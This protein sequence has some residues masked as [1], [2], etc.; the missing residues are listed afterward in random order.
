MMRNASYER[1]IRRSS[2]GIGRCDGIIGVK[3]EKVR[4][5][6]EGDGPSQTMIRA[7]TGVGIEARERNWLQPRRM[8]EP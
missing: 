2:M 1:A 3:L 4:A 8:D 7:R 6:S 5:G